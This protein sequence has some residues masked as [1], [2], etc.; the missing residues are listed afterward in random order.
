MP[1]LSYAQNFEDIRLW[2]AFSDVE[3]GRYID[4]GTQDPVRDSVS[5]LFYELGW[6]GVHVE[7]TPTYA[8][9][10]RQARPDER[11]IE[12]AVSSS[13]VP[14]TL[15]E[16]PNTGLSTGVAEIAAGH[17]EHGFPCRE[18]IVPTVSLA[19]LFD[20]AGD[21]FV[22]WLKIDVEGMEADVLASWGSHAARPAALVIEATAPT[23]QDQT[24]TQWYDMVLDRG[25]SEVLFD[26]L[27]RYFI[28]RD[29]SHRGDALALSP[30]VFDGFHVS[31]SHFTARHINSRHEAALEAER[32][33]FAELRASEAARSAQALADAEA[34]LA[35][36]NAQRDEVAANAARE[37]AEL[38]AGYEAD[39]AIIKQ[40]NGQLESA[41][42]EQAKEFAESRTVARQQIEEDARKLAASAEQISALRIGHDA[43]L[44]DVGRLEGR[45]DAMTAS[46]RDRLQ[47]ARRAHA[48]LE[49]QLGKARDDLNQAR[50]DA[51]AL[52]GELDRQTFAHQ[53][54]L[55]ALEAGRS[56]DSAAV[57]ARIE[58][59]THERDQQLLLLSEMTAHRDGLAAQADRLRLESEHLQHHIHILEH[60]LQAV[61]QLIGAAPDLLAGLRWPTRVIARAA[62]GKRRIANLV[63]HAGKLSAWQRDVSQSFANANSAAA[64][65]FVDVPPTL[66]NRAQMSEEMRNIEDHGPVN[67]V[68]KLLAPHDLAFITT[69]YRAVLGR[70]PEPEG[71]EYYLGR[72]RS[73]VHKLEIVRQLR[74]SPEGRRF[75]PGVAGMDRAIKRH[76]WANRPIIGLLVRLF[77]GEQGNSAVQRQLRIIVNELGRLRADQVALMNMRAASPVPEWNGS[78]QPVLVAQAPTPPLAE[79][80]ASPVR[81]SSL[82]IQPPATFDSH[83]RR[84]LQDLSRFS[85]QR[86][87]AT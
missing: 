10:M 86:S 27:S 47:D 80:H 82:H 34:S 70:D 42:Q 66:G 9:A 83:E 58:A 37:T 56:Q 79:A 43:L 3:Q 38:K 31:A 1:L 41:L 62:I 29:H 12:A 21:D 69:A 33:E 4:I 23:S 57:A 81:S 5:L 6:R 53:A 55:A 15:F 63:S 40:M 17:R 54:E 13:P 68:P 65:V 85:L 36:A 14:I 59:L 32:T 75:V 77:T 48:A 24:H 20:F 72:L 22:H 61:A 30:N 18:I 25:Y 51:G 16:F 60:N 39:V 2:R 46:H 45:L 78:S 19:S 64:T 44:R 28:H 76:H 73:G 50:A 84:V 35:A 8:A 52:R 7:P 67:T 49:I 26:G 74:R 87:L 71:R 11:V